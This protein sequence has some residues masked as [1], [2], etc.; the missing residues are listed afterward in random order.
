[1]RKRM[2]VRLVEM[3]NESLNKVAHE[4]DL[5]WDVIIGL[6]ENG[7]IAVLVVE[8]GG[9]LLGTKVWGRAMIP[10][11]A[12]LAREDVDDAV[13]NVLEALAQQR[14]KQ[15]GAAPPNGMGSGGLVLPN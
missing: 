8:L 9:A 1:M 4:Q 7:P 2:S 13:R 14:E 6:D 11:P 12:G 15:V 5:D 3:V 10:N